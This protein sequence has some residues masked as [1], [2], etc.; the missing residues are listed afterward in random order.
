MESGVLAVRG[1]PR[2]VRGRINTGVIVFLLI[3]VPFLAHAGGLGMAPL[4]AII[5]GVGWVTVATLRPLNLKPYF[6]VLFVFLLWAWI[7]SLWSPYTT[8][9]FLTNPV[10]LLIGTALFM[11]GLK[12]VRSARNRLPVILPHIFIAVNIFACGLIILDGLSN[13][14]LTFLF[15]PLNEQENIVRKHADVEMNIGHS[16]TILILCLGPV[17]ALMMQRIKKGWIVALLYVFA[18]LWAA[19]LSGLA[20]GIL[21]SLIVLFALIV[22]IFMPLLTLK[23]GIGFAIGSILFAPLIGWMSRSLPHSIVD[24]LPLSWEHRVAMWE[25]TAARIWE[26]PL[27]GH[28]FDAVRTFDDTMTLGRAENWRIVS[29][30]PHNAGLHIWVET[31]LIG[32]VLASILIFFIGQNLIKIA[33]VSSAFAMGSTGLIFAATIVS[34]VTYGVWQD[35]WWASII[36]AG[37]MLNLLSFKPSK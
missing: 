34:S 29:L 26:A 2:T 37:A 9:E 21:S 7:T 19:K 5:G 33:K 16:V 18:L 17:M 31:G 30:H 13:Y 3:L 35:W 24:S 20:V 32:A 6:V 36:F 8:D 28:G 1:Q 23:I 25:F 27:W 11:G 12:A 10:K 14:G 22:S 15:D 4:M